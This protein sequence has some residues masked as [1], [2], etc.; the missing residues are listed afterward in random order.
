MLDF[1][2]NHW[3]LFTVFSYITIM[4]ITIYLQIKENN[5]NDK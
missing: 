4:K 2:N 3:F 1:A 5:K